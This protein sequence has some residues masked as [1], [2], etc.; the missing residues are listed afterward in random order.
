MPIAP[1]KAGM[2]P[3]IVQTIL[4]AAVVAGLVE[5]WITMTHLG[6][7]PMAFLLY[8]GAKLCWALFGVK[9]LPVYLDDLSRT[10]AWAMWPVSLIANSLIYLPIFA[11]LLYG[12]R[13]SKVVIPVIF[14]LAGLLNVLVGVWF[15]LGDV[16]DSELYRYPLTQSYP[17][18]FISL[19]MVVL[20]IAAILIAIFDSNRMLKDA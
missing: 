14:L 12:F 15:G 6:P 13:R 8:P 1:L 2:K 7:A 18:F 4:R 9:I 19:P 16:D 5:A 11:A 20:G 3:A 10:N 17:L